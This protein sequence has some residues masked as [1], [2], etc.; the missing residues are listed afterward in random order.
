MTIEVAM[1][2]R[3]AGSFGEKVTEAGVATAV[4]TETP[5]DARRMKLRYGVNQADECRDF[6]V[7]AQRESI[8]R[9]LREIDTWMVRLFVFD[10][11]SAKCIRR[12]LRCVSSFTQV[13]VHLF[14]W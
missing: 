14:G 13:G 11:S 9:A 4:S 5:P 12:T 7:G 8:W 3:M 1:P 6:A 10:K 2:Q